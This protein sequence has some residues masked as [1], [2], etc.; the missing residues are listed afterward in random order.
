MLHFPLTISIF[1]NDWLHFLSGTRML[2][3]LFLWRCNNDGKSDK[4]TKRMIW[5]CWKQRWKTFLLYV[6]LPL[7]FNIWLKHNIGILILYEVFPLL[8]MCRWCAGDTDHS[9]FLHTLCTCCRELSCVRQMWNNGARKYQLCIFPMM[10]DDG[11][12]CDL[13]DGTFTDWNQWT[14]LSNYHKGSSTLWFFGNGNGEPGRFCLYTATGNESLKLLPPTT[15]MTVPLFFD[16]NR[17]YICFLLQ[18]HLTELKSHMSGH[19]TAAVADSRSSEHV[20]TNKKVPL[21]GE[22]RYIWL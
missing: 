17:H 11:S 3:F 9:D 2:S 12:H 15:C 10:I 14:H 1:K 20:R 6:L 16:D 8:T 5:V 7:F 22:F 19:A 21:E 13:L 18:G 4:L